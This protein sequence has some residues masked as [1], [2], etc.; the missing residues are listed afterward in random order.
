MSRK[1][2]LRSMLSGPLTPSVAPIASV[3]INNAPITDSDDSRERRGSGAVRAMG[4]SLDRLKSDAQSARDM[5]EAMQSGEVVVDLDPALIDDSFINDRLLNGEDPSFEEF[6]DGIRSHGQHTPILVRP[7][8]N[9]SGRYEIAFG[10][11]RRRACSLLGRKV[12]AVVSNL[13]DAELVIAQGKENSD[14]QDPSFIERAIFAKAME[15]KQFDRAVIM[16]ALSVHKTELSRLLNIAHSIPIN[17]II[18]IG[19]AR[20]TGRPRWTALSDRLQKAADATTII[21]RIVSQDD[22]QKADS[23]RRFALLFDGL[24]TKNQPPRSA[25]E[26][27]NM[28]GQRVV[29]IERSARATKLAI[30]ENIA[31]DFGSFLIDRLQS[32]YD[33]FETQV[34][35]QTG[36]VHDA[37]N[38]A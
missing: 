37:S 11:R 5:K 4:L 14:R 2:D 30:D 6:K 16:S 38:R 22:F 10:R 17:V 32:L 35:Q 9:N 7:H 18:A 34:S 19:P 13:S 36:A 3:A 23:D 1:D 25:E 12:R 27:K 15:D 33:E 8:P 28:R 29:R 24:E 21:H 26:W 20:K 31:P